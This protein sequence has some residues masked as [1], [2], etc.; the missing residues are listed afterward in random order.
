MSISKNTSHSGLKTSVLRLARA[1]FVFVLILAVQIMAYDAWKLISPEFVLKRWGITALLLVVTT[2]VWAAAQ[3]GTR[4]QVFYERLVYVL[5]LAD[6]AVA[7]LSVYTQRGMASRAVLLYVIPII[8]SAVL[9]QRVAIIT[10]AIL[11]IVAYV[12]TAVMYFV[13]NFNEG[14]KIE[15][16]G[17]IGFYSAAFLLL[18]SLLWIVVRGKHE[19]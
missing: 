6:I 2:L 12:M 8:V 4:S 15:L 18:A 17:E 3:R 9:L 7:S 1:H 11:C 10:T 13:L 16:Y 19:H 14:Y 5:I